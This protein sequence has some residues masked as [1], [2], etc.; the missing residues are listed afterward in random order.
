[1]IEV[2]TNLPDFQRQMREVSDTV[3]KK[4][5]RSAVG[6]AAS[7]FRKAVTQ[8]APVSNAPHKLAGGRVVMPGNLKKNI[9]TY[10]VK[11]KAGLEHY[12]VSVRGGRTAKTMKSGAVKDAYYWKWVHEGHV[13]GGVRG[14]KRTKAVKRQQLKAAGRFI[15]GRP[16]LRTGFRKATTEALAKFSDRL[17]EALK[18]FNK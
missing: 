14:G 3:K 15:Q 9:Y 8:E 2:R 11:P 5:V 18:K 17:G 7:V 13:I 1:M 4:A 6:A 12:K 10:R 16:F